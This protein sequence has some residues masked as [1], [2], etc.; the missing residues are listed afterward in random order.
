ML[1]L[2]LAASVSAV[3]LPLRW[4][5]SN[6]AP[7]GNNVVDMAYQAGTPGTWVHVA[8]RGQ[9]YTSA[10]LDL[11]IPRA[12]GTT[13][14]LRAVTF[15]GSRVVVTGEAGTV[16]Y[17]DALDAFLPGTL[18]DNNTNDWLEAVAASPTLLVA[19]GDNGAIYTSQNGIQ[20]RR[21]NA[22]FTEWLTGVAYGAGVFVAVGELGFIAT[23]ADGTNWV[24]RLSSATADLNRVAYLGSSRFLAVGQGG[25]ALTSADAGV[26][27]LPEGTGA[28]NALHN[29]T[30]GGTAR[31]VV[32]AQEVR[33]NEGVGWSDQIATPDGPPEWT[34]YGNVGL[35]GFFSIAGRTGLMAEGYKTNGSAFYWL[36]P[37]DAPRH[38]LWEVTHATN[39]YVAVGDRATVM[40]SGDGVN[41]AQEL[42][43][44]SVTNSILLGVGGT[45]NLLVAVGDQGTIMISP[46]LV[47]NL[48]VTNLVG[49]TAAITSLPGS[50][51]GVLWFDLPRFTTN[52]LQGVTYARGFY[53]VTGGR[54]RTWTSPDGTNWTRHLTP[55][56][57]FLS[58]VTAWR[59]GLV[60]VGHGG[61]ILTSTDA[62][63]WVVRASGTTNWLY[64]VRYLGTNLVAV[65]QSGTI[66]TSRNGSNW[67][68]RAS[69]T[70][71]WLTDVTLIGDTYFAVGL[72][73]TVLASTNLADWSNLGTI[74]AKSLYSAATDSRQL[75]TVGD[76]GVILRSPVL[77]DL[78]PIR[79]GSY[80]RFASTNGQAVHN[81]FLFTGKP[82]Q[83][84]TLDYR[85]G[86][87]TNRWVTGPQLEFYDSDGTLYYLETLP[88]P[89][90]PPNEF[91][92]GS[93][94]GG[95]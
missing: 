28:T 58:G 48:L 46:N 66:R 37:Q 21:R 36:V 84:F 13:K 27:W 32:G 50:T 73:G 44:P 30:A 83:R 15:F 11:W 89:S 55:V 51:L 78:T 87:T 42:V 92:R 4:R 60:A 77:P 70:S 80:T 2:A 72:S 39:L 69:G 43:P 18:N 5:F 94:L 91:Y 52:D 9:I 63:N 56:T 85:S 34:Y 64:R 19:V 14:A 74:T 24:R 67:V 49:S 57:N 76:E 12:S 59:D 53:V 95:P 10:D 17:A 86:L 68:V 23:S 93:L 81:L 75:L 54:G 40:T 35:P 26:T 65:G 16:L 3:D 8:E 47:T 90:A 6:P 25:I 20:W 22:G 71:A 38:L 31:L 41:W 45:T 62:T 79:I 33:L 7:H 1:L 82:D 61:V 88:L 29:A